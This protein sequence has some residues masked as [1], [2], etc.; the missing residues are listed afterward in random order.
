MILI[1]F[2]HYPLFV[3]IACL[4]STIIAETA[5]IVDDGHPNI[6][7]EHKH[8]NEQKYVSVFMLNGFNYVITKNRQLE[9][10]HVNR[11]SFRWPWPWG[12]GGEMRRCDAGRIARWSTSWASLKATGC[13]YQSSA[14]IALLRRPP[15]SMILVENTKH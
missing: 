7:L 3:N 10:I 9:Q 5:S 4:L 15:W 12:C 1:Y 2:Y 6:R 13:H 11:W 8:T 14:R